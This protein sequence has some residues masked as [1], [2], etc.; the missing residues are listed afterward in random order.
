MPKLKS[1]P[2]TSEPILAQTDLAS[3]ATIDSK[4]DSV[5]PGDH[6][7]KKIAASIDAI[8][9]DLNVPSV[10]VLYLHIPDRSVP[11]EWTLGA[12]D[13]AHKAGKFKELG[14]SNYEP[15]EVP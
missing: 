1:I 13:K 3:W 5:F 11:F 15:D 9:T 2:H 8:L 10:N 14:L 4:V 6:N 7:A 12:L